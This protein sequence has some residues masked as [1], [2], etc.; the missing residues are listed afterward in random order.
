MDRP[1]TD[2]LRDGPYGMMVHWIAPG[3]A[4]EHGER[5]TD[6]DRAVDGFDLD[7]FLDQFAASGAAW[8]IFTI[9]QNTGCYASPNAT[10]DRL[11]GPGHCSR[12]DLVGE[13]ARGVHD[14]GRRFIAYLP[15]EV[16]APTALHDAFGWNTAE[17]TDQREFQARYRA[18]FQEYAERLGPLLDGWWFDGVYTW[19]VFH[20]SHYDW[21]A[22]FAAA[23]AGNPDALIALNDGSFCTG[24]TDPVTPLQD[25]LS[26]EVN[27][28]KDGQIQLGWAGD[29]RPLY[30]PTGRFAPGTEVQWH[31]LV[32]VDCAWGHET[33]GPMEPP[34]YPDADLFAFVRQCTDVG[35][36]VTLNAG[37]FQDGRVGG[38]T[39]AQLRRLSAALGGDS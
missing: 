16:A 5:V 7:A 20:N 21:P 25:Y 3:P 22:W 9:G 14:L 33:P 11:A 37:I 12:R 24:K 34:R 32:P 15:A 2:W 38:A 30:R 31:A 35:G 6:L 39:L 8:L 19:P 17:G 36:A 10:L 27:D 1:S 18:F 4:P 28:L 29:E 23:R 26:G 13:I